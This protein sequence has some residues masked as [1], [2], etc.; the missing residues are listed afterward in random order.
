MGVVGVGAAAEEPGERKAASGSM[1]SAM[2]SVTADSMGAQSAAS[3]ESSRDPT[4][5][6]D[7]V[8]T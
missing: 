1:A 2:A 3:L 4:S 5:R 8:W 6:P 7:A